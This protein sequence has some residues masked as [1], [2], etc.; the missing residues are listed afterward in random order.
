[1]E[2]PILKKDVCLD[3]ACKYYE[4]G[5]GCTYAKRDKEAYKKLSGDVQA[6]QRK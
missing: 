5:E 6:E 1:M 3:F 2:C 4:Q